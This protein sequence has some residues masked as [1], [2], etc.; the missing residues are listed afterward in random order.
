MPGDEGGSW[1]LESL[2]WHSNSSAL[3]PLLSA[4]TLRY[5]QRPR[6]CPLC[7][8][9]PDASSRGLLGLTRSGQGPLC[10]P[11]SGDFS[12]G[13]WASHLR[14]AAAP[15]AS[16][17][18]PGHRS[19]QDQFSRW[20]APSAPGARW[21][22]PL[23]SPGSGTQASRAF[24]PWARARRSVPGGAVLPG[25]LSEPVRGATRARTICSWTRSWETTAARKPRCL[26]TA[27]T[28]ACEC[29]RRGADRARAAR[30]EAVH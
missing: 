28:P 25:A 8:G 30:R 22:C 5:H 16:S 26:A 17:P 7:P 3:S 11:L 4:L 20:H 15:P 9:V 19:A 24:P 23:G 10:T 2:C 1:G 29:R 13:Q 21:D 14:W 12:P 27:T 6:L 18:F